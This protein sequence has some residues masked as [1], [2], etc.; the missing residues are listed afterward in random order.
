MLNIL[1][2]HLF[3]VNSALCARIHEFRYAYAFLFLWVT[4]ILY[5]TDPTQHITQILDKIAIVSV[6]LL[7]TCKFVTTKYTVAQQAIIVTS[8]VACALSYVCGWTRTDL[9]HS[10]IIHGCT[11]IGHAVICT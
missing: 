6:V 1:T 3:I 9:A 5:H 4:S 11:L 7:G 10:I 2:A 8:F